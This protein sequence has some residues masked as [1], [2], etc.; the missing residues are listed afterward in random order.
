MAGALVG[1][2]ACGSTTSSAVLTGT[3]RRCTERIVES[4]VHVYQGAH[5][6]ASQ[7]V[8]SGQYYRFVLPAGRYTVS[9]GAASEGQPALL[10]AGRTT[11]VNFP[12]FFCL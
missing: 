2:G 5:Q 11:H 6:V 3:V 9:V 8:E 7:T 12:P 10:R 4:T 1:L